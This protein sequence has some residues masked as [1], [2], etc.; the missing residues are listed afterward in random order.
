[1]VIYCSLKTMFALFEAG[2][3]VIRPIHNPTFRLRLTWG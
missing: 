3:Q 2:F 1:M